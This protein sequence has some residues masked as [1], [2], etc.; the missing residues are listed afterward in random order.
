M[1]L[2]SLFTYFKKVPV[3]F[4]PSKDFP[5]SLFGWVR[6]TNPEVIKT[7]RETQWIR[8]YKLPERLKSKNTGVTKP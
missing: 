5:T 3:Y 1:N 7:A 8:F 2:L 4:V 6:S